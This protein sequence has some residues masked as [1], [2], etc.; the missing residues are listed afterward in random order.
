VNQ[1]IRRI[2]LRIVGAGCSGLIDWLEETRSSILRDYGSIGFRL[3]SS[4]GEKEEH[5]NLNYERWSPRDRMKRFDA[6][7]VVPTSEL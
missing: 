1:E 5:R 3:P 2:G 4:G 6:S 7:R